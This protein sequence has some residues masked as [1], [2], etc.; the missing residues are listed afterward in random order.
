MTIDGVKKAEGKQV[1]LDE[2]FDRPT[3]VR[4]KILG[5]Y[6]KAQIKEVLMA[7]FNIGEMDAKGKTASVQT[8]TEG[9]ADRDMKIRDL[10]ISNAFVATNIQV[11]GA[12]V[13]WNRTLWD[14]LDD[15]DPH[16]VEKVVTAI[17]SISKI[18]EGG[19][20]DPT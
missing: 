16:I 10:K 14:A 9:S 19:D 1:D 11:D 15:A 2:F 18:V 7:W 8:R 13:E 5:P 17:D 6:A 12:N 20:T 3:F 4:V